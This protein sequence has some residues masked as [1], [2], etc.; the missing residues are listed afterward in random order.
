MDDADFRDSGVAS[1]VDVYDGRHRLGSY[2]V[3]G[4]CHHVW[5][6]GEVYLGAFTSRA[7]AVAAINRARQ[8]AEV[9]RG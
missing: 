2:F 8:A 4:R 3:D 5:D 9:A 1:M 6:A 7:D